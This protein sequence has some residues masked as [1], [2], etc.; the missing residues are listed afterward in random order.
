MPGIQSC[1]SGQIMPEAECLLP[2]SDGKY[3]SQV[4]LPEIGKARV[5]RLTS[6]ILSI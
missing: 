3:Q 5:Y 1:Q 4:R 6:R 2:G